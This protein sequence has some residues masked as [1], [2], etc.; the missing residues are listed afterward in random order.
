MLG[1][2]LLLQTQ[3]AAPSRAVSDPGVIATGQRVTPAG[4]QSV[5]DGR[6]YGVRFGRTSDEVWVASPGAAT[7]LDWRS[8]RMIARAPMNG[9]PGVYAVTPDRENGRVYVSSVGALLTTP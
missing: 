1:L 5:F 9:R 8:N 7:L 6:V 4:V 3:A 2:A